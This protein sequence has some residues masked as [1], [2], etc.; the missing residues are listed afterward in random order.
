M[1]GPAIKSRDERRAR[2]ING[3]R[4]PLIPGTAAPDLWVTPCFMHGVHGTRWIDFAALRCAPGPRMKRG[5][6]A[7]VG[8]QMALIPALSLI[9]LRD[10]PLF[11]PTR[12]PR[13]YTAGVAWHEG[14][15]G[16]NLDRLAAVVAVVNS[17]GRKSGGLSVGEGRLGDHDRTA[18]GRRFFAPVS[19]GVGPRGSSVDR[20]RTVER[21]LLSIPTDPTQSTG[22]A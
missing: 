15:S 4:A 3:E 16:P 13:T 8:S 17:G 11:I 21:G 12:S 2:W 7:W 19:Q 1:L 9:H 18:V 20:V 5:M 10:T 6:T 14:A 22:R